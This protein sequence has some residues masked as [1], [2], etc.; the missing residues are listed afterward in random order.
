MHTVL[1]QAANGAARAAAAVLIAVLPHGES[2][3]TTVIWYANEWK[4]TL[5]RR[6]WGPQNLG[7][8]QTREPLGTW[9]SSRRVS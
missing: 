3:G 8:G 1:S 6:L 7:Y 9:N 2:A 4:W 5:V